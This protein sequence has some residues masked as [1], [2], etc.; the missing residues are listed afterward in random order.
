MLSPQ[1]AADR[2]KVSRRTVMLAIQDK[3]L[4]AHRN[5]KNHWQIAPDELDR[6]LATRPDTSHQKSD[7]PTEMTSDQSEAILHLR[8]KVDD[9][10]KRVAELTQE[11][12]EARAD[13]KAERER[14]DQAHKAIME[15]AK[16]A[17]R[18]RSLWEIL[19]GKVSV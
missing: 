19:T 1:Q 15:I 9:L 5:N 10:E 4:E 16:E 13:V 6:W 3:R 11:R 2:A 12:D 14:A 17:Q 8:D 7:A 18:K